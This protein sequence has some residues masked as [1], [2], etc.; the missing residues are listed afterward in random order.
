[1]M[2]P[3]SNPTIFTE[4]HVASHQKLWNAVANQYSQRWV[5]GLNTAATCECDLSKYLIQLLLHMQGNVG[6]AGT[7]FHI[8]ADHFFNI[9]HYLV[10]DWPTMLPSV[11]LVLFAM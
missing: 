8:T 1:M 10:P 3:D 2:V 7:I 6:L 9:E 11:G 4:V 5:L